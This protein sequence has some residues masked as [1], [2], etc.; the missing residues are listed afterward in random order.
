[1]AILRSLLRFGTMNIGLRMAKLQDIDS[2]VG[3]AKADWLA[4]NNGTLTRA[5]KTRQ[6][7]RKL[8]TLSFALHIQD[9]TR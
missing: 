6:E 4:Q 1:M 5:G 9:Y 7:L 2:A 3:N 8:T